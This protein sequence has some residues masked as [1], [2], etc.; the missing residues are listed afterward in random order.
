MFAAL[1]RLSLVFSFVLA[2]LCCSASGGSTQAQA[3]DRLLRP[4]TRNVAIVV[5]DGVEVLDF[6][7]PSE[8][9]ADAAHHG[10]RGTDHA[11]R[12]FT[13]APTRA[14][15]T[16]QGFLKV[17]PDYTFEN[18]PKIDILVIPG[19]DSGTLTRDPRIVAAVRGIAEQAELTLTV[20]SGAFVLARTGLLDGHEATTYYAAVEGLQGAAPKVRVQPGR[21]FIDSGRYVTTAG[22]SAGI[23]GA[24]HVVARLLGRRVADQTAR[25]MEY[26]WTPEPYLTA[27][28]RFL[29]PSVDERGRLLQQADLDLE[30]QRLAQAERAF[31]QLLQGDK[32]DSDAWLGLGRLFLMS[33]DYPRAIEAY[34]HVA[35]TVTESG[36]R[37]QLALYNLACAYALKQD[38]PA[39]LD[40]LTRAV[41]AGMKDRSHLLHDPDL[42]SLH[43]EP[44][45]QQ[46]LAGP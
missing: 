3:P 13:V 40:A 24:L 8:V 27:G 16:S 4:Y 44:R 7:G 1:R 19:G 18:T 17:V 21:R 2:G 31:R 29:N 45:F 11:F 39:A 38:R 23:D 34:Q 35:D 15:I 14:P 42:A 10:A 26:R 20:C 37:R 33:G 36:P 5:Y 12:L 41:S 43:G 6:S 22:V 32:K 46:L 30:E 25:N 9:F 28:Y